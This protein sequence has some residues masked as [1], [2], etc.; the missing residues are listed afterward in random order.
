MKGDG[1]TKIARWSAKSGESGIRDGRA[2]SWEDGYLGWTLVF[3]TVSG[4]LEVLF[5]PRMLGKVA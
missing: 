5:T 1:T 4:L 2:G 3:Q